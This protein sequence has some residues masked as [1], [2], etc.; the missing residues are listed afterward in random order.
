MTTKLVL[1]L[2]LTLNFSLYSQ[3]DFKIDGEFRVRSE[4]D[5]RDFLNKTYPQSFTASR[6]R[7]NVEKNIFNDITIFVQFQDS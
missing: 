4:L 3:S 2:V 7:I 6:I 1:L 5:G